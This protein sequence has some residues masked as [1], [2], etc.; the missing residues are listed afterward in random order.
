MSI[1]A[2]QPE[3]NVRPSIFRR[4]FRQ[5]AAIAGFLILVP[6]AMILMMTRLHK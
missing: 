6:A 2:M 3:N 5:I 4:T 1:Q